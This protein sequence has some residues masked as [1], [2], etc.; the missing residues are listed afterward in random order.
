MSK[1]GAGMGA[2]GA[3]AAGSSGNGS[4]PSCAPCPVGSAAPR[5][6]SSAC[7]PCAAGSAAATPGAAACALCAPGS[8]APR[9]GSDRCAAC[10][11]GRYAALSGSAQCDACP[12]HHMSAGGASFCAACSEGMDCARQVY[13]GAAEGWWSRLDLLANLV[14]GAG[15]GAGAAALANGSVLPLRDASALVLTDCGTMGGMRAERCRGGLRGGDAS[16]APGHVGGMCGSCARGYYVSLGLEGSLC[17]RC[18]NATANLVASWYGDGA[19]DGGDGATF[20]VASWDADDGHIGVWL[21]LFGVTQGALFSLMLCLLLV[22]HRTVFDDLLGGGGGGGDVDEIGEIGEVSEIDRA[23]SGGDSIESSGGQGGGGYRRAIK[24]RAQ[25]AKLARKAGA[26]PPAL[27]WWSI[28]SSERMATDDSEPLETPPPSPPEP[29]ESPDLRPR[30][31]SSEDVVPTELP[32]PPPA[33]P[34]GAEV[35]RR[36]SSSASTHHQEP[37]PSVARSHQRSVSQSSGDRPG[38]VV[39]I[40]SMEKPESLENIANRGSFDE[41]K[42]KGLFDTVRSS[43]KRRGSSQASHASHAG[44]A[45]L[46]GDRGRSN[47]DRG[48]RRRS[49]EG[50]PGAAAGAR[51]SAAGGVPGSGSTA[52]KLAESSIKLESS[53]GRAVGEDSAAPFRQSGGKPRGSEPGV[54]IGIGA[55]AAVAEEPSTQGGGGG[56]GGLSALRRASRK[57][58]ALNA[59]LS[60]FADEG[61]APASYA[62][63]EA[64]ASHDKS[65]RCLEPSPSPPPRRP[66]GKAADRDAEESVGP[67]A[68]PYMM[69]C[70]QP[71]LARGENSAAG[72]GA[73]GGGGADVLADEAENE[74]SGVVADEATGAA[75]G[76]ELAGGA[77]ARGSAEAHPSGVLGA[78]RDTPL[79]GLLMAL[80][81]QLQTLALLP[82]AVKVEWPAPLLTIARAL[83]WLVLEWPPLTL[84]LQCARPL[85][86]YDRLRGMMAVAPPLLGGV[87]VYFWLLT[88]TSHA[89]PALRLPRAQLLRFRVRCANLYLVLAVLLYTPVSATV[90]RY[91]PCRAIGGVRYLAA[92]PVLVCDT[93][94]HD[95]WAPTAWAGVAL[96]V[97]GQPLLVL[98]CVARLARQRRLDSPYARR[99]WGLAYRKFTP[100]N[101]CWE[102][103]EMVQKLCFTS[104]ISLLEERP[105]SQLALFLPLSLL[106]LVLHAN[107]TPYR[108]PATGAVAFVAHLSIFLLLLSA[109]IAAAVAPAPSPLPDALVVVIATVP[110]AAIVGLALHAAC[111]ACCAPRRRRERRGARVES[112]TEAAARQS[113][114]AGCRTTQL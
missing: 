77:A 23:P 19:G 21:L 68:T 29:P 56:G 10:A 53:V 84:R 51:G 64:S 41:G 32:V 17:R 81:P 50:A 94:L 43:L 48:S 44:H 28:A 74:M 98:G 24:R 59:A 8:F 31:P 5:A 65:P 110:L 3:C 75:G 93:P 60:P 89:A 113:P 58:S 111:K 87:F 79:G 114:A 54:G 26:E 47:S 20:T 97:V 103:L 82:L 22:G 67:R 25:Q 76:V 72:R 78:L 30:L 101:C 112:S 71:G 55:A 1:A 104:L 15:A 107:R 108:D 2:C 34:K 69:A 63:A 12:L 92:D 61:P 49:T 4:A 11:A 13:G 39:M 33:P 6:G 7:T 85:L 106:F 9:G 45:S 40:G 62:A 100:P 46:V 35:A 18:E 42:I 38:G 99:A 52:G 80:V 91:F 95:E 88:L 102:A 70:T 37:K 109:L 27:S 14:D 57:L 16:C 90:L 83:G 36:R 105:A 66:G 73:G 96:W 86:Y